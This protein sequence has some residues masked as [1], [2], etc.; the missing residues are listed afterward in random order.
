MTPPEVGIE[1]HVY[2]PLTGLNDGNP[3]VIFIR[4]RDRWA[5]KSLIDS[6]SRRVINWE[7]ATPPQCTH[8]LK[9][10]RT[11]SGLRHDDDIDISSK[12]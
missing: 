4:F 12:M 8:I 3:P 10:F 11:K 5:L 2:K 9:T 6:H 7:V 1:F